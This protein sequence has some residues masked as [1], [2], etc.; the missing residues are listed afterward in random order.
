M[1]RI[2][3]GLSV[4]YKSRLAGL[5]TLRREAIRWWIRGLLQEYLAVD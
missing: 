3:S 2:G 4:S 1:E 5:E